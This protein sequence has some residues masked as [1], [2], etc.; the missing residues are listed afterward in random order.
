MTSADR[1]TLCSGQET[2]VEKIFATKRD[3]WW[4]E[5]VVLI[6][7]FCRKTACRV[8]LASFAGLLRR[9]QRLVQ[10][11]ATQPEIGDRKGVK[12]A[13]PANHVWTLVFPHKI[14]MREAIH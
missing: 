11:E 14:V 8:Q 6:C 10:S 12:I 1:N 3:A 13:V 7:R 2:L 4:L 9:H 5:A